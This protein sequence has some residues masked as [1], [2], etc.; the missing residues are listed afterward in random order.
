MPSMETHNFRSRLG[1]APLFFA[2]KDSASVVVTITDPS[3]RQSKIADV[4]STDPEHDRWGERWAAQ[5]PA[6]SQLGVHIVLFDQ[7][8]VD[9]VY[10][11]DVYDPK[12]S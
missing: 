4:T 11:V 2:P 8:G 7:D 9:T 1:D 12:E 5:L 6:F 10:Y 3:G